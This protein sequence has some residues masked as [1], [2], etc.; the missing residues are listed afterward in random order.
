MRLYQSCFPFVVIVKTI[1][2]MLLKFVSDDI[3]PDKR[4]RVVEL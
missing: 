2:Q 1:W 3:G 4:I